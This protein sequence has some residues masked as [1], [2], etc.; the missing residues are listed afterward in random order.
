[1]SATPPPTPTPAPTPYRYD[2]LR[3]L[4]LNCT[5]KRSPAVSNTEGLIGL[6]RAW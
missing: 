2:D 6:S 1:M 4:Y 3:A 5:L